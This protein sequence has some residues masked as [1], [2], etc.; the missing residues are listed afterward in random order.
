MTLGCWRTAAASVIGSSHIK[1]GH[2]CQ[3]ACATAVLE[4]PGSGEVLVVAVSDGAGTAACSHIGSEFVV[5]RF[6]D[7]FARSAMTDPSLS[8]LD[9]PFAEAWLSSAQADLAAIA[10]KNGNEL[11]NYACTLLGAIITPSAS[12][13]F[14]IGDGAIIVGADEEGQYDWVTWPQHGEY[15]NTT[16]FITQENAKHHMIFELGN[17]VDSIA[18]FSDGIERLVLDF[19]SQVVHAPAFKPIFDWLASTAPDS[20]SGQSKALVAY[21]SSNQIDRRTDDDK[22]LVVA[23]RRLPIVPGV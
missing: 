8:Q 14:H 12:A 13:Y 17:P 4:L 20:S 5:R 21:L 10:V 15:A 1:A 19:S 6:A 18:L 16:N 3:D 23:T 22:T 2:P 7:D 11:Q 9:R